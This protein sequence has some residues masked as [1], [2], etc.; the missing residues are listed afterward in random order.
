MLWEGVVRLMEDTRTGI[1]RIADERARQIAE[2]GWTPE[3]DDE[4]LQGELALVGALY[5]TPMR[6]FEQRR[7][8][9]L[10][11]IFCDPWP[12]TWTKRW[13]KRLVRRDDPPFPNN[14]DIFRIHELE[15]AGALVAAEIDRLL[16]KAHLVLA[17]SATDEKLAAIAASTIG[18]DR[19]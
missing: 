16:R 12:S 7:N 18:K 2:E 14:A 9:D 6:L 17:P 8:D 10:A 19:P 1:Q 11:V 3:H 15:K 13:D 4:H 5:A